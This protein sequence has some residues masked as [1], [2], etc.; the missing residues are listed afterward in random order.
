MTHRDR[1]YLTWSVLTI[2]RNRAS[3]SERFLAKGS[4]VLASRDR[5]LATD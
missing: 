3:L 4:I 1:Q 5:S 2:K